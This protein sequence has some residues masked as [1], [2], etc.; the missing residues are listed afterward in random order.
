MNNATLPS[1]MTVTITRA[2][3][4]I[5]SGTRTIL[6]VVDGTLSGD[7]SDW[8]VVAPSGG[9]TTELA[10]GGKAVLLKGPLRGTVIGVL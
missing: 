8:T 6:E 1:A 2:D 7:P 9:Y 10:P 4:T 3:S 5:L